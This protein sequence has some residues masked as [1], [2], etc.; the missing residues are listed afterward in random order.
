MKETVE[1][2]SGDEDTTI[3]RDVIKTTIMAL[4]EQGPLIEIGEGG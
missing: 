2:A 3:E 4:D 1:I